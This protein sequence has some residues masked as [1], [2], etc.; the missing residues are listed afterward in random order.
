[1]IYRSFPIISTTNRLT[2]V[3]AEEN[4]W[5][6][7]KVGLLDMSYYNKRENTRQ[8]LIDSLLVPNSATELHNPHVDTSRI[9]DDVKRAI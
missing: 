5:S 1:M 7:C 4:C 9:Q 8:G 2:N 6:N 3:I